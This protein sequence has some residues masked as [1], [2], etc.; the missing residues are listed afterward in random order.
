MLAKIK[1]R[2]SRYPW[3]FHF[4]REMYHGIKV[5]QHVFI[6][7]NTNY[8]KCYI[9]ARSRLKKS[10]GKPILLTLEPNNICNL[11]CPI[12]ETGSSELGREPRMMKFEEFKY[13]LDQFDENLKILY[14]YFMGESFLNKDIYKMIRYA[15]DRRLYVSICTNGEYV[16]SEKLIKSGI[17]DIQFQIGG[18]TPEIHQI[19]RKGGILNK[20][21][22]KLKNLIETKKKYAHILK[23][24]KYPIKIGLGF[25]L[26]RHNEHQ[27]KSFIKLAKEMEVDEYQII[28]PC[29][30]NMKQAREFLPS[31]RN[32]WIYDPIAFE[33]GKLKVK[34]PPNNY[35]EWIYSTVTV[36]VNG[37]VVP[38]CRDATG[39]YVLGNLFKQNINEVWN[40]KKFQAFRDAL[41]RTQKNITICRLCSGYSIPVYP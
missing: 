13:I 3:L 33:K 20:M 10:L 32:R 29:V 22:E 15:A 21:L 41:A 39:T 40:G 23:R 2:L 12:C 37:D 1:S 27:I 16:N 14:L 18:T 35:C 36:Q 24:E 25:I 34:N 26:M 6:K 38:C 17:A 31:N 7:R 9:S 30:R 4:A 8:F 5:V 28:N 11:K 19:Y